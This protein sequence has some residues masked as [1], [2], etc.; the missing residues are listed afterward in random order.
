[1]WWALGPT[2]TTDRP[3]GPTDRPPRRA[4][5]APRLLRAAPSARRAFCALRLLTAS[6]EASELSLALDIVQGAPEPHQQLLV[7]GRGHAPPLERAL[8]L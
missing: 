2:I 7:L 6:D 4:F 1:M 8:V 5:C 3:R